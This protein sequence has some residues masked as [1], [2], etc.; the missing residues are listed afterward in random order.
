MRLSIL[1]P[2]FNRA[3]LLTQAIDAALAQTY[4][5]REIIV[6]DDGSTDDTTSAVEKYGS[7]IRYLRK[8]NGG[9][10]SAVNAGISASTGDAIIVLD[11]DDIFPPWTAAAHVEALRR[12]RAAGFSYGRFVRFRGQ[13]LPPQSQLRDVEFVPTRDPR[14]LLVKLMENCFLPN[15]AWAARREALDRAGLYDE[16]L[17]YCEDYDMILRLAR[18]DEGVFVDQTVLYQRKHLSVRG[19]ADEPIYKLDP[20]E[21]WA[22]YDALLFEKIDREWSLADFYPFRNETEVDAPPDA[23]AYLQ[24]AIVLFQRKVYQGA[25]PALDE[26]R[27][28]LNGRPPSR[29]ELRIAA[30]LLGC[31]YGI[32]DLIDDGP[33]GAQV[34]ARLRAGNW[35]VALRRAFASQVRWR[36]RAAAVARDIDHGRKLMRF[37]FHA[38]GPGAAIAAIGR[39]SDYGARHWRSE[40]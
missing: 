18:R 6:I 9:K 14:R 27:R 16:R 37:A 3:A 4:Q 13:T 10:A 33:H 24:K 40:N 5:Q 20:T 12:N 35:P 8:Q 28:R 30:G 39:R 2:T 36:L 17:R 38:F 1:I 29:D 23:L 26:Y 22:K 19:P 34:A 7:A 15:P 32:D 25:L 11:D 21:K 31:R